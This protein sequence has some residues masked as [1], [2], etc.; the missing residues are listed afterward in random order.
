M[1]LPP[2]SRFCESVIQHIEKNQFR[3]ARH[4]IERIHAEAI[5]DIAGIASYACKTIKWRR[6]N[7]DDILILPASPSELPQ[8]SPTFASCDRGIKGLQSAYNLSDELAREIYADRN[9]T[10]VKCAIA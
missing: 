5:Y 1:A 10:A 2:K 9:V 3:Y 6:A 8:N 7:P 4:G